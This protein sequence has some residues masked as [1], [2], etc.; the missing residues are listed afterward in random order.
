MKFQGKNFLPRAALTAALAIS[1]G[2][3]QSVLAADGS[4]AMDVNAGL[5]Q[6]LSVTC[7]TALN[8]GTTSI[9]ADNDATVITVAT[10]GGVSTDNN[11]GVA[12]NVNSDA[13]A[14]VCS[15]TGSTVATGASFDA[16]VSGVSD[17]GAGTVSA[18]ETAVANLSLDTFKFTTPSISNGG[19][20]FSIGANLNIPAGL[21]EA[22]FGNYETTVTVEVN[23]DQL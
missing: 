7:G 15:F 16:T 17:L 3:S 1:L 8:F 21:V 18:P 4:G 14:G 2:L 10:D 13:A 6:A 12:T 19:A 22:N 23:D 9:I 20:E 11:D 5:T